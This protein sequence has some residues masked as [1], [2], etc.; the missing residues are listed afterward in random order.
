MERLVG[1]YAGRIAIQKPVIQTPD[2]ERLWE[3]VRKFSRLIPS[4]PDPHMGR[5][6][7]IKEAIVNGTYLTREVIEETATHLAL[8]FM[9][10]E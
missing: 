4:E 9:K 1:K 6:A 2:E 8:R 3:A 7:E 5:I 10:K